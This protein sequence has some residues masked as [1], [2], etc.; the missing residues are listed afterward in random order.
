MGGDSARTNGERARAE[1]AAW[2]G[3]H[4]RPTA[5]EFARLRGDW[6]ALASELDRLWRDL[7]HY[8]AVI[9][10]VAGGPSEA[11]RIGQRSRRAVVGAV[12]LLSCATAFAARRA[13]ES[14]LDAG[15]GEAEG[16]ASGPEAAR[17]V[18]P[19]HG[20]DAPGSPTEAPRG[21]EDPLASVKLPRQVARSL[22]AA[23]QRTTVQI[24]AIDLDAGGAD[25]SLIEVEG[26]L[27]HWPDC[28]LGAPIRLPIRD[29]AIVLEPGEWRVTVIDLEGGRFSELRLLAMPGADLGTQPAFLRGSET[30]TA[31]ME[32]VAA[33]TFPFGV[34]KDVYAGLRRS[35]QESKFPEVAT[36]V[37]E[38]FID[39]CETT[40]EEWA[41]FW[42]D[43]DAHPAW[44]GGVNPIPRPRWLAADGSC[45]EELRRHPV[46]DVSWCDATLYAN[47]AG[48]RLATNVEWERVAKGPAGRKYPWGDD[49]L[50]GAVDATRSQLPSPV[51]QPGSVDDGA[52]VDVDDP[53]YAAGDAVLESGARI[54]R[55]ADNVTEFV[56]DVAFTRHADGSWTTGDLILR[57]SRG[58]AW[59][60]AGETSGSALAGA[61]HV[62]TYRVPL[63]TDGLRCARSI[64]PARPR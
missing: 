4:P 61:A 15:R 50:S 29:G 39:P 18:A 37:G 42:H 56:E 23:V 45:P 64:G 24:K 11:P 43:L 52:H 5:E 63:A 8:E 21:E 40:K 12:A 41:D 54:H 48:K 58:A 32:R 36:S 31:T 28:T 17:E 20:S 44:C 35:T 22:D 25:V 19:R 34:A 2:L 9:A 59:R 7:T 3:A 14:R 53:L 49:Y 51:I 26:Q 38:F 46:A 30:V 13:F 62:P 33:A 16:A 55:M 60:W 10:S 27:V 47:W 57:I 6:P 1:F